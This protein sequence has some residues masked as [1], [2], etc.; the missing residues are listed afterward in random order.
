M[1]DRRTRARRTT[2]LGSHWD[3]H[4]LLAVGGLTMVFPF[5]WQ[6]KL[7]LSSRSEAT[8]TPIN[9]WPEV[10]KWENY[11]RVFEQIP[12]LDHLGVTVT[13]AAIRIVSELFLCSLAGYAFARMEFPGK[14]IM[15]A[16]MLSI[17]MVPGQVYLIPQYEL[18]Q[19]LGWVDTMLGLVAP[20]LVSAFGVF[21][22]MQ[23]FRKL[24]KELEESARLDGCNPWQTYWRIMLPLS[25]PAL[26]SFGI[27][28][29]LGSW[30]NLLWPLV[31]INDNQKTPLAVGLA[32]LQGGF[33]GTDYPVLMAAS[34]MAML[35]V[36]V[37]FVLLQRQVIDGIA[38]SG[39][40]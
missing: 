36:F 19:R 21:L 14:K 32:V 23:F 40:K 1:T 12:M 7:S 13:Y 38:M 10:L 24:P 4:L 15:F 35:P 16:V 29:L 34:L 2:R 33:S 22:M 31:V 39:L 3:A 11:V 25:K 17:L 9:W 6:L 5:L 30:N 28:T 18:I 20:G 8:A 27:I 37:L 26:I